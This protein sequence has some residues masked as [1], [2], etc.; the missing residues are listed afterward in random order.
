M[1]ARRLFHGRGKEFD[2][3][4]TFSIDYFPSGVIWV[5]LFPPFKNDALLDLKQY[6]TTQN[7][8]KINDILVQR[9]DKTINEVEVLVGTLKSG[10][11]LYEN[12]QKYAINLGQNQN[13]G[14]FLDMRLGREWVGKNSTDKKVLNLF[15]YT[16]SFSVAAIIGGARIV[17]NYDMADGAL[18]IGRENHRLNQIPMEKVKFYPHDIFKSW[19]KIKANGP[20]DLIILDPPYRQKNFFLDSDLPKILKRMP[21]LL[22]DSG[23]LFVAINSPHHNKKTAREM[24]LSHLPPSFKV[25]E[26]LTSPPEFVERD[27]ELGLK[28]FIF[29]TNMYADEDKSRESAVLT[30][31]V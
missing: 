29:T 3:D 6:L 24:I 4:H 1:E 28:I 25:C 27:E 10:F 9:R 30:R 18:K 20:Y 17:Y 19:G 31:E 21:D 26:E 15:S 16:C 14:F 22:S 11:F 5:T 23:K 13:I 12:G 7:L 2:H 8:I